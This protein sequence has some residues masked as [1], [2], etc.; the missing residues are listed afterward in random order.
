[1]SL[2]FALRRAALI[3]PMGW[4]I[5]YGSTR[6][7]WQESVSRIARLAGGL[8]AYGL[9]PRQRVATLALN[10]PMYF[11]LL[12]AVWWAGGVLV[13]LNTRLAAEE[14]TFIL[15]HSDPG[16]LIS[17]DELG[18]LAVKSANGGIKHLRLDTETYASLLTSQPIEAATPDWN[19][20]AAE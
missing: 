19:S 5:V 4:A 20:A 17:D 2:S 3:R 8:R 9:E 7:T 1:M 13:P 10:S 18:G 14:I 15:E 6:V 12:L 11:E 16:L